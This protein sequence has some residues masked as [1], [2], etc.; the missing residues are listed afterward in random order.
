MRK[1]GGTS[2]RSPTRR[3]VRRHLLRGAPGQ[4]QGG[5]HQRGRGRPQ[6]GGPHRGK[7]GS[8]GPRGEPIE[9]LRGATRGLLPGGMA[10]RALRRGTPENSPG[11][12]PNVIPPER[13]QRGHQGAGH[14][15]S[16]KEGSSEPAPGGAQ[17]EMGPRCASGR[18][19]EELFPWAL[20]GRPAGELLRGGAHAD[21]PALRSW[22]DPPERTHQGPHGP[23][24]LPC[25]SMTGRIPG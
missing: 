22:T 17:Q 15:R 1:P 3:T 14:E 7:P 4:V 9:E 10:L 11:E 18:C 13:G 23:E 8:E 25:D 21:D 19:S 12:E 20:L 2:R 6:W 24:Q 5:A 16:F